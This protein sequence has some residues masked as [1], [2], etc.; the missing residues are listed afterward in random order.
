MWKKRLFYTFLTVVTLAVFCTILGTVRYFIRN[1]ALNKAAQEISKKYFNSSVPQINS[2][3][4]TVTFSAAASEL[5]SSLNLKGNA[6]LSFPVKFFE[7]PWQ[8]NCASIAVDDA[9]WELDL[10]QNTLNK[11]NLYE[12]ASKVMQSDLMRAENTGK[13]PDFIT[14]GTLKLTNPEGKVR[15]SSM[16]SIFKRNKDHRLLGVYSGDMKVN[17]LYHEKTKKLIGQYQALQ[18]DFEFFRLSFGLPELF[19]MHGVGTMSGQFQYDADKKQLEYIR[20]G[21]KF[22]MGG[23][24]Q[25]SIFSLYGSRR[26][27]INWEYLNAQNWQIEVRNAASGRPFR[28]KLHYLVLSQ[29]TMEPNSVSFDG[30]IEFNP[31]TFRDSFGLEFDRRT[32]ALR[33]R[34][35]GKWNM[36]DKSWELS[37]LDAGRRIPQVRVKWNDFNIA[38]QNR[39]FKLSGAGAQA[40]HFA[41][42][43][44]LEM[45]NA[46]W[47]DKNNNAV[48]TSHAKLEGD[49]ILSLSDDTLKP[50][51]TGK[52]SCEVADGAFDNTRFLLKDVY[53]HFS[54][55]I[56]NK[57]KYNFSA[58]NFSV[59][60]P[61]LQNGV[62]I[63][64]PRMEGES[65]VAELKI[66]A[67]SLTVRYR[68]KAALSSGGAWSLKRLQDSGKIRFDTAVLRGKIGK[69]KFRADK[70]SALFEE[71]A[72]QWKCDYSM[73]DLKSGVNTFSA[74]ELRGTVSGESVNDGVF[75]CRKIKIAPVNWKYNG[76][77]FSSS[78]PASEFNIEFNSNKKWREWVFNA[79]QFSLTYGGRNYIVPGLVCR[80]ENRGNYSD[81]S[82]NG[83]GTPYRVKFSYTRPEKSKNITLKNGSAEGSYEFFRGL[84]GDVK[85][86]EKDKLLTAS[87]QFDEMKMQNQ[88]WEHGASVFEINKR[89]GYK[90]ISFNGILTNDTARIKFIGKNHNGSNEFKVKN[91]PA[92]YIENT[93]KVS[94]GT[95][96]GLF[97]GKVTM[98]SKEFFNPF[99]IQTFY[100]KNNQ[101]MR[102]RLRTLDKYAQKGNSIED[103]FASD[104]LKDFFAKSLTLDYHKVGQYKVLN[105]KALGKSTDLLP[106][107]YDVKAK[108]LRES[109]V[110]LFN[111]EVE[112]IMKYM[113]K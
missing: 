108:K 39:S 11:H 110:S 89:N 99:N 6:V 23:S 100:L 56:G 25:G 92:K 103:K 95:L 91:F 7:L 97:D 5:L 59:G 37:R 75:A 64:I 14:Y 3:K 105:V 51:A 71:K 49:C 28:T 44:E 81:G 36:N 57:T 109:D 77:L 18:S 19:T 63:D 16:R 101:V 21:A 85:F 76:K 40:D 113:M 2:D 54:P 84:V 72:M 22:G 93:L 106:Y 43:Y 61:D 31:A 96:S 66:S 88:L 78:S 50:V 10:Q 42:R 74:D 68:D 24:I 83:H 62:R 69:E 33:H 46:D 87:L 35:V 55:D 94:E 4:R 112:V 111:S 98:P 48:I 52:I 34:L 70:I 12:L 90:L 8:V 82:F 104:A 1:I 60:L 29:N 65:S 73:S 27:M 26:G 80:E 67:P 20:G 79:G 47:K 41:F 102:M 30:E 15:Q 86:F 32:A 9:S 13:F 58:G 17:F 53:L 107:E 38:F 45:A